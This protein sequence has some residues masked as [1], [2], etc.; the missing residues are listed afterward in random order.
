MYPGCTCG[1]DNN[2]MQLT[3]LRAAA[4]AVRWAGDIGTRGQTSAGNPLADERQ[5]R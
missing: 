1:L 5:L 2:S 4:D 3:V